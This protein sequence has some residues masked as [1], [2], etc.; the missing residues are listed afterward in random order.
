MSEAFD[1]LKKVYP[2]ERYFVG[3]HSQGGYL[4]Y[5]MLMHFPEKIAGAFPISCQVMI[6][7]EPNVFDNEALRA[8]QRSVPLAIVHGKNDPNID[9]ASG[10]QYAADLYG[11]NGWPWVHLFAS[12]TAGHQ[13][14]L[15]PVRE[16][17]RWLE[18]MASH[19]PKVLI[20]FAENAG[21][22][23]TLPRRH[24]G[25]PQ[26]QGP[27]ADSRR[28]AASRPPARLDRHQGQG[29]GQRISHQDPVEPE[30]LVGRR[31]PGLPRPV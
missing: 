18:I 21:Q 9:F 28:E 6:Q 3:G 30:R 13:F 12:E 2:V 26:G 23:R 16:A 1:E 8:A 7:C 20:D 5:V 15:L 19:E 10:G 25:A 24:R 4:T 14:M 29:E 31:L 11:E 17:I 22:G 27:Q